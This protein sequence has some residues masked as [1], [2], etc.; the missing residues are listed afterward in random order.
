MAFATVFLASDHGGFRLKQELRAHL[1]K[2]HA[3]VVDLGPDRADS[4]DYP[5]YARAVCQRVLGDVTNMGILVCGT[6]LGMSMAA[7]RMHGIRAAVCTC[8]Y[9]A[10][11]T[12]EHNDANVLCLGERVVGLGLALS[13]VDAFLAAEFQG[14]RHL[15]RIGLLDAPLGARADTAL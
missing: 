1:E 15:R 3:R 2:R 7:N 12:R 9:T 6:G 11:M 5:H 8:E 4:C 10:R 14:G 13:I